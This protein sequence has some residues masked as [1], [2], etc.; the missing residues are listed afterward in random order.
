MMNVKLALRS[1]AVATALSFA[2]IPAV[3]ADDDDSDI[4]EEE[5]TEIQSEDDEQSDG[6]A[7]APSGG[8]AEA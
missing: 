2:V 8:A 1:A 3:L 7:Q 4:D 5:E 6:E